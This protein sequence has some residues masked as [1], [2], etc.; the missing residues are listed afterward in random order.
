MSAGLAPY[1]HALERVIATGRGTA[2]DA[3]DVRLPPVT[4]VI[5]VVPAS[6]R[7][8]AAVP[9]D[10]IHLA[11]AGVD[12]L[13]PPPTGGTTLYGVCHELG[14]LVVGHVLAGTPALPVVWDEAI[15]HLLA[16]DVLL[17]AVWAAHGP[18]LWP[19]TYPDYLTRETSLPTGPDGRLDA[20]VAV[21]QRT[22]AELRRVAER[23]GRAGL[24][25]ALTALPASQRQV[26]TLAPALRAA[27]GNSADRSFARGERTGARTT[28]PE[29]K[30]ASRGPDGTGH[31]PPGL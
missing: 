2:R 29:D 9:P 6:Q 26:T 30:G 17:P 8:L 22:T 16:V 4:L 14:H 10:T 1:R 27:A 20:S 15:A 3:L 11:V 19:D 28:R 21:L 31:P 5:D 12:D 23:L 24:L 18:D 25:G 7:R 13:R